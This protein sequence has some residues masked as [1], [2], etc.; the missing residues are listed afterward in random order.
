MVAADGT[1]RG[2]TDGCICAAESDRAT[3]HLVIIV[4]IIVP[5]VKAVVGHGDD[6]GRVGYQ[7]VGIVEDG[8]AV[9]I[10]REG[11]EPEVLTG[12][13]G[14]MEPVDGADALAGDGAVIIKS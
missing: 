5:I 11:A 14:T 2:G 9:G 12:I 1:R 10:G 6:I 13:G 8:R 3:G 4:N 7:F